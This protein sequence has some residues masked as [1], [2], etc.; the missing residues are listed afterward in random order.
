MTRTPAASYTRLAFD[1]WALSLE[2]SQVMWLRG[3]RMMAGG[4]L[5]TRE[6]E[7]MLAEK[8]EA[9]LT[10]WPAIASGGI[11]QSVEEVGARALRHYRKPVRANRR[12]LAR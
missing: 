8:V 9:A 5:A 1:F 6:A 11:G 2:A 10:L 3:M 7:R 4:P 12:R